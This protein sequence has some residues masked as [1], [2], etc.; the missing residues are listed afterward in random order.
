M[1]RNPTSNSTRKQTKKTKQT[2][3]GVVRAKKNAYK[4]EETAA[5]PLCQGTALLYSLTMFLFF[6][7]KLHLC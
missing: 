4:K 6:L 7:P 3:R 2:N 5:S 1:G